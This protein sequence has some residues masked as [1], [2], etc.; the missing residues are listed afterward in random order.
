[1]TGTTFRIDGGAHPNSPM[2]EVFMTQVWLITDG[3]LAMKSS[4][5]VMVNN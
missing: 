4:K 3:E 5:R 1:M 2:R